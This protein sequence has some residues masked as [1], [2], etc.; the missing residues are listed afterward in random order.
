[1]SYGSHLCHWGIQEGAHSIGKAISFVK[2]CWPAKR[3]EE[4]VTGAKSTGMCSISFLV[5]LP[6]PDLQPLCY[7][8]GPA[9]L[10]AHHAPKLQLQGSIF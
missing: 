5:L 3:P 2:V 6:S 7:F 1:M 10:L 9:T 8:F 4:Q